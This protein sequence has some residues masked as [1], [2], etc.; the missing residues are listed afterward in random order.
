MKH[1]K[2]QDEAVGVPL[3]VD[4]RAVGAVLIVQDGPVPRFRVLFTERPARGVVEY[5]LRFLGGS[6]SPRGG[7][8]GTFRARASGVKRVPGGLV[9]NLLPV[10]E[11]VWTYKPAVRRASRRA[12]R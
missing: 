6:A 1:S 2:K 4:G 7:C 8:D 5:Q 11:V 3:Y 9:A 10:G 12:D